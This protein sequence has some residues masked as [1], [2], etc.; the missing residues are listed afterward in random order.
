MSTVKQCQAGKCT[1]V[2]K[3][4]YRVRWV[5]RTGKQREK[6]FNTQRDAKVYQVEV[7]KEKELGVLSSEK[8]QRITLN[9]FSKSVPLSQ[10]NERTTALAYQT[11]DNHLRDTLGKY[12]LKDI[13]REDIQKFFDENLVSYSRATQKKIKRILTTIFDYGSADGY[14]VRNPASLVT[15]RGEFR[16]REPQPLNPEQLEE[17]INLWD[18][19]DVLKEHANFV[20]AL[21]YTG[22]RPQELVALE[23]SSVDLN[24]RTIDINKAV[25]LTKNGKQ[26]NSDVLK[27]KSASRILAIDDVLLARLRFRRTKYPSDKYVFS[28]SLGKQIN[29]NNFRS[30]YWKRA[31][32]KSTLPIEVAYDLRHSFSALMW[33]RGVPEDKLSKMMGHSNTN[34]T[35]QWYGKWYRDADFSGIKD[36]E[37]WKEQQA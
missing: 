37:K 1:R 16:D 24:E 4:C 20:V 5:D 10:G 12:R 15:L 7:E 8:A 31:L 33:S 27:T 2:K 22:A 23:W 17:F 25:K 36:L 19:D 28:S 26:Y 35:R 9:E 34:V 6:H 11:Y 29:L 32:V 13:T 21:A 3:R 30:R 18:E 14:I